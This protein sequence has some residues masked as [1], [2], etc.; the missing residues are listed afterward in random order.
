MTG[1]TK[2]T[3][4][5][6]SGQTGCF[7]TFIFA[8]FPLGAFGLYFFRLTGHP[9]TLNGRHRLHFFWFTGHPMA[10]GFALSLGDEALDGL[11]AHRAL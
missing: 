2:A 9:M 4:Q 7:L 11:V 10:L 6:D 1:H 3:T 8:G 5:G